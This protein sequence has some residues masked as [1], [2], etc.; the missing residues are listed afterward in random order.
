ME[1][2]CAVVFTEWLQ[3]SARLHYSPQLLNVETIE[4]IFYAYRLT[5]NKTY[6][7]WAWNAFQHITIA[8]KAPFG[9]SSI[10]NVMSQD[11][12]NK[13]NIQESFFLAE[14]L[15]YFY[16]IFDNPERISLDEWVFN[17]EAH[18]LKRGPKFTNYC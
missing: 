1:F 10:S 13:T 9:F 8:T 5:G 14:T 4:S 18:P 11:G 3:A 6:Q 7:D 17:T 15:K 16:L 12:G 2:L